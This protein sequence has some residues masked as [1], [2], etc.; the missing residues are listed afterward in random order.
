MPQIGCFP[1]TPASTMRLACLCC[2]ER[3]Q[4]VRDR[5][6]ELLITATQVAA[7]AQFALELLRYH[8]AVA[9]DSEPDR[10][11][12]EARTLR[13]MPEPTRG[14]EANPVGDE[15]LL[16]PRHRIH[17]Q[18]AATLEVQQRYCAAQLRNDKTRMLLARPVPS[19]AACS[20]GTHSR[21]AVRQSLL[22]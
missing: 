6:T 12:A 16:L 22:S 17:F 3:V 21:L 15:S 1:H 18:V 10:D 2:P 13:S 20:P 19:C 9:R 14:E 5:Q 7:F 11:D 8:L 4:W